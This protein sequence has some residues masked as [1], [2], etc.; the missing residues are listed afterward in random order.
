ME[1]TQTTHLTLKAVEF[2]PTFDIQIDV[3]FGYISENVAEPH[4]LE[5]L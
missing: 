5:S 2:W 3:K 1:N 4:L